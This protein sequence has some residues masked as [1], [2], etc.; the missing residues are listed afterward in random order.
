[1]GYRIVEGH[2]LDQPQVAKPLPTVLCVRWV[3]VKVRYTGLQLER[4]EAVCGLSVSLSFRS[5]PG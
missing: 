1:M 3:F 5:A 2:G 4:T